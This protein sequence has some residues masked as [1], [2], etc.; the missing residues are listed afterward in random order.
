[1][2]TINW[3]GVIFWSAVTLPGLPAVDPRLLRVD[4]IDDL[5]VE[6]EDL[7]FV[8]FTA[9]KLSDFIRGS[10]SRLFMIFMD[11]VVVVFDDKTSSKK[12]D[13]D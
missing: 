11:R 7:T 6:P 10:S 12:P 13:S 8:N 9:F 1:M 3:Y 5:R 4:F 2:F